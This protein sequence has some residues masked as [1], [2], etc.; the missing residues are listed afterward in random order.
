MNG[1]GGPVAMSAPILISAAWFP[2]GER[3]RAT[4][5]GQMANALGVGVSYLLVSGLVTRDTEATE[6]EVTVLLTTYRCRD[7]G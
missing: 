4:S 5:I 3:T 1:V 2:A 7:A 6:H